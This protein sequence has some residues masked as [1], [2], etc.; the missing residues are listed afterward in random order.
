MMRLFL[1][2][3]AIYNVC[4]QAT[5]SVKALNRK[6]ACPK[7][8]DM[9]AQKR[10]YVVIHDVRNNRIM[11]NEKDRMKRRCKKSVRRR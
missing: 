2:C 3:Q 5:I 9:N 11:Q 8:V 10:S 4:G 6:T 1:G 7:T